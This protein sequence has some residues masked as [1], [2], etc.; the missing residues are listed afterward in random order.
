MGTAQIRELYAATSDGCGTADGWYYVDPG[1]GQ[2][3]TLFMICPKTCATVATDGG[4]LRLSAMW[5]PSR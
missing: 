5:C 3:P 4:F 2:T 1:N